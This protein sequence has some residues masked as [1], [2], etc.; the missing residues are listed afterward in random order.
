MNKPKYVINFQDIQAPVISDK[1]RE[2]FIQTLDANFSKHFKLN[3]LG[4]HHITLNP[5]FRTSYPHAESLEEEFV[6]VL[7]G[8]VH[9]WING[10][11]Y[12]LTEGWAVGFPAATGISHSFINNSSERVELLVVGERTKKENMYCYPVNPELKSA[13][14]QFWWHDSPAQALGQHNGIPGTV[15]STDLKPVELP[16]AAY[17][18]KLERAKPF[19]Y[20][21]DNETFGHGVRLTNK[22]GLKTLGIWHEILPPG[23]RSSFPHAHT[24]EE[25]FAYV[26][27]G[28][29]T[30]WLNGH[31]EKLSPGDAV[32]F[33]PNTAI[34]H[35]LINDTEEP[36]IY[37]SLGEATDFPDEKIIYPLN[38]LRNK[39]CARRSWYWTDAPKISFGPHDGRPHKPISDHI[40]FRL[41]TESDSKDVLKI[42]ETS[43]TYFQKVDGCH[44]TLKTATHAIVDGP[45]KTIDSFFKEFLMIELNSEPIGTVDLHCDHPEKGIT[46][47]G[48]LLISEHLFGKGLGKRCYQL[49][50]DY[51]KCAFGS[52]VIR[53]GVSDD[54]D[55]SGFWR[56]V[57]FLPNGKS[58]GAIFFLVEI[59]A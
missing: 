35:C 48:L 25:E 42:F 21:G 12:E 51:V 54:N 10:N 47:L 22:L 46:Y 16:F 7:S 26:I 1:G 59:A 24:H 2:S 11:I 8:M 17:V 15:K 18:P 41:C 52:K 37:M 43:P 56:A 28:N 45:K 55:V 29:P 50:E 57:G 27:Q 6:Y 14:E 23:R 49:V 44:P 9:A 39:E 33:I 58:Y 3:R 4:V 13:H 53:I 30:V 38:P 31:V 20:P 19:H 40:N 34:S 36:V 32:A 5:G